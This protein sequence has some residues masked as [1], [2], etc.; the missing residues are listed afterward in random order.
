MDNKKQDTTRIT[1]CKM[2]FTWRTVDI[3][4][5]NHKRN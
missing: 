5:Q 2:K 3:T 1:A 4:K